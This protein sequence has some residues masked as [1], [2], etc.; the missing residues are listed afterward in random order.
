[1]AEAPESVTIPA[2][3]IAGAPLAL[4]DMSILAGQLAPSSIAEYCKDWQAYTTWCAETGALPLEAAALARWRTH[5]AEATTKSP[6]TINR[7]LA[8]VKRLVAE[9]AAQG[10]LDADTAA[11]IAGVKGV[12]VK[13][14]KER[15]R[16]YARTRITPADMRRLCEAPDTATLK[17][18]RDAALLAVLAGSGLRAGEVAGLP[19]GAISPKGQ[20]YI[21]AVWGK[22]QTEPCEALL[23]R[24]AYARIMDWIAARPVLSSYV[25]TAFAGRG[26]AARDGGPAL[27][28]IGLAYRA[29]VH[30]SV[31]A[32]PHQAAR[33]PALSG[34]ADRGHH[35]RHSQSPK[36][37]GAQ[38]HRD[39]GAALR[40][41]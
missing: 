36:G 18:K 15:R 37:P 30:H 31:R 27:A 5:L 10:Y 17:G 13:A 12:K 20:G 14:L 6:A 28:H 21:L 7:A 1:M 39:D 2:L 23:T 8:A 26:G 38:E 9:G 41:R 3:V 4:P 22:G 35:R 33:F 32:G 40:A 11:R 19:V 25:F 16:A 34:H 29:G 24:E